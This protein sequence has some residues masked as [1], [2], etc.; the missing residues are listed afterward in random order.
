[1]GRAKEAMMERADDLNAAKGFLIELGTLKECER[2]GY[3]V[4]GDEDIDRV[5]PI[6]MSERGKGARGK[7]PWAAG[8]TGREFTDLL[9]EAFEDSTGD[10][11]GCDANDRD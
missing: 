1:M 7:V 3:V 11:I 5:W 8:M 4:G 9:K 10:C 6:A 2:H